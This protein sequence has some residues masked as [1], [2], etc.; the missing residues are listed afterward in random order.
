MLCTQLDQVRQ[1]PPGGA[2]RAKM[3]RARWAA[4]SSTATSGCEGATRARGVAGRS[5]VTSY[6]AT[7]RSSSSPPSPSASP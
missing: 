6:P 2:P 3:A 5:P 1:G 4:M 7:G